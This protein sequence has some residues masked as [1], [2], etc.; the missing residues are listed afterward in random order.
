MS[1]LTKPI[2]KGPMTP[3]RS[4]KPS[5]DRTE[6]LTRFNGDLEIAR[7]V[8]EVFLEDASRSLD[9][10]GEAVLE[11]NPAKIKAS[12]HSLKGALGNFAAAEAF[13]AAYTLEKLSS[14]GDPAGCD[15]I[16]KT[17]EARILELEKDLRV[18]VAELQGKTVPLNG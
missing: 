7:E 11:K 4:R 18:L 16:F 9:E 1:E 2:P 6:F 15:Q 5:F 8:A 17:L 12:A 14:G 13:E 3:S 10:V